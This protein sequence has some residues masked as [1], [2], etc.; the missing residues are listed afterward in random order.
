MANIFSV[1]TLVDGP[2]NVVVKVVGILDTADLT[3]QTV[4]D[5]ATLSSVRPAMSGGPKAQKVRIDK[6]EY[7][8][9]DTIQVNLYWDA[10]T[11]VP[12]VALN[13]RGTL[14]EQKVGGLINNAGAGVN[15]K[16]TLSTQGWAGGATL[17]FTL[18]IHAVKQGTAT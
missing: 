16:V 12:I 8:I 5:P 2:R 10:T 7:S 13:G 11:P 3:G 15:G 1:Q 4:I 18:V 14:K 6:I 9:E 17:S